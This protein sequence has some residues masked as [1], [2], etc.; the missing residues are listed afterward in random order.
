MREWQETGLHFRLAF[1]PLAKWESNVKKSIWGYHL[2]S[3]AV[4]VISLWFS[5]LRSFPSLTIPAVS[6]TGRNS[7]P[8]RVSA[9]NIAGWVNFCESLENP[10]PRYKARTPHG[11]KHHLSHLLFYKTAQ[12][13]IFILIQTI[14]QNW[15]VSVKLTSLCVVVTIVAFWNIYTTHN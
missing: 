4:S 14:R 6:V 5:S 2:L 9:Q 12:M 8:P 1:L 11:D 3:L 10:K 7:S 15:K 13:F